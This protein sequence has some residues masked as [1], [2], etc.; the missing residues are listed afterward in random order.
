MNSIEIY[1]NNIGNNLIIYIDIEKN[2]IKIND[3]EKEI[4]EEKL[5]NLIRIIRTWN[6][7]YENNNSKIDN[8]T[9]QIN[10]NTNEGTDRIKGTGGYPENYSEFKDWIGEFYG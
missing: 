1:I 5:D 3:R 4:T 2:K 6:N 7:V 8:E 10:I 9:F